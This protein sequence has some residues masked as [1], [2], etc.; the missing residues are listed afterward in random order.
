MSLP[1]EYLF[2]RVCWGLDRQFPQKGPIY[3]ICKYLWYETVFDN[4]ISS[5]KIKGSRSDWD[6]L[7]PSKSMFNSKPGHGIVIGNLTSQWLSNMAL[8]P[9]D[10]YVQFDLGIKHYGRYVDDAYFVATTRDELLNARPLIEN[11]IKSLG[12]VVH[13]KKFYLQS[14]NKGIEFLGVKVYP[15]RVILG[16]RFC[17][18]MRNLQ[19][20][21]NVDG[22]SNKNIKQS[23]KWYSPVN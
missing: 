13:P 20:I 15:G 2:E 19:H 11:Y 16:Q 1:R 23:R 7:P 4:P 10:R 21:I 22:L 18:N 8:D 5:V 3:E 12:M 9:F 17:K 6:I 14:I